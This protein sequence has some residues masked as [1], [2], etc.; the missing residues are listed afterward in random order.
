[1]DKTLVD[2]VWAEACH[3]VMIAILQTQFFNDMET[4]HASLQRHL[5]GQGPNALPCI[6][7]FSGIGGLDLAL[8]R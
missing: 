7:L 6:S 5:S 8:R 1:M 2:Q 4:P 3:N